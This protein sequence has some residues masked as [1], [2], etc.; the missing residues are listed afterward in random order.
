VINFSQTGSTITAETQEGEHL[1]YSDEP[2]GDVLM[3]P[4]TINV[5]DIQQTTSAD[6]AA[7]ASSTTAKEGTSGVP[8]S[9]GLAPTSE[10][11]LIPSASS[12]STALVHVPQPNTGA[13]GGALIFLPSFDLPSTKKTDPLLGKQRGLHINP[14]GDVR[15][16]LLKAPRQD[17]SSESN[18]EDREKDEDGIRYSKK[19]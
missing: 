19:L 7:P 10:G 14:D 5:S 3:S 1:A 18:P 16:R 17:S 6:K 12:A 4:P 2:S 13:S 9:S 8:S 11:A 15:M